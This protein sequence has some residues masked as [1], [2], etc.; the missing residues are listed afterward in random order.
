MSSPIGVGGGLAPQH[1][2]SAMY[3]NRVQGVQTVIIEPPSSV[4]EME[5]ILLSFIQQED[6]WKTEESSNF[7]DTR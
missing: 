2:L 7:Y 1:G 4:E 3:E 6:A 5:D